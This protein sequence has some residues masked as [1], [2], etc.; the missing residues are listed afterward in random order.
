VK[1]SSLF[2]VLYGVNLELNKLD[3]CDY[4]T[5]DAIRFVSR[6]K[7]NNG[8]SAFVK[9]IPNVTPNPANTI[10]VAGGGTY[11][12]ASF[13]Q[14]KPYYSGRDV[15][16][17]VP[18][19]PMQEIEMIY[20]CMCIS[21]NRYKYSYG[22]QANRTLGDLLIPSIEEIQKSVNNIEVP[23]KPSI[24]SFHNKKVSLKDR[25]WKWINLI[26]YFNMSAG[27]YYPKDSYSDGITPLVTSSDNNNGIMSFTTLK[28]KY[29][30]CL[31][32]GKVACSVY[33]QASAFVASSD[34]TILNP[35]F[36]MNSFQAM[37]IV[38][39]INKEGYKWSYGRQIRLNDS[40]KLKIKLPVTKEGKPDWDFME[41]YI[42]TLNYS[43][44]LPVK[45]GLSDKELIDK[46][47]SGGI[48]LKSKLKKTLK[49]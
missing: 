3:T 31:T 32:I 12:L 14:S 16:V 27:K 1:I 30:N 2:N 20:Y 24:K 26:D 6:S 17:L 34:V 10:S 5:N 43:S 23:K 42:K 47:E 46:Y 48:N 33:Y 9:R 41:Y 39:L 25:D 22:R 28:P 4:N 36:D 15:F 37:F 7:E 11:V 29:K 19:V 18:I 13:M 44:N 40:E 8:V 35:K 38:S 45:K 21:N 49:N